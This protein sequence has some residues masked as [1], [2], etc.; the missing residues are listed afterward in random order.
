[1]VQNTIIIEEE[2]ITADQLESKLYSCCPNIRIVS[3][4]NSL[5]TGTEQI[6]NK[7]PDIVFLDFNLFEQY[8]FNLSEDI[9]ENNFNVVFIVKKNHYAIKLLNKYGIKYITKPFNI[10]EII[11]NLNSLNQGITSKIYS[12]NISH[13]FIRDI[14]YIKK[15]KIGLPTVDGIA[16][17]V[18]ENIVRIEA[19]GNNSTIF[20]D[21]QNSIIVTRKIQVVETFLDNNAF[22]RLHKSH[23]VN[24][25]NLAIHGSIDG[26]QIKMDDGL[27]IKIS[28]RKKND[29]IRKLDIYLN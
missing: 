24:L 25:S 8:D 12:S 26:N 6:I 11:I 13:D 20:F 10:A 9:L 17:F 14:K 7:K 4:I 16:E 28:R 22:Y 18:P 1:M 3:K 27:E 2:A 5:T 15:F 19:S 21:D 29:L 23:I